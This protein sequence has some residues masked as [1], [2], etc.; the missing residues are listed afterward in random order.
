MT[1]SKY[2]TKVKVEIKTWA[3]E[4]TMVLKWILIR[5]SMGIY[6]YIINVV[7]KNVD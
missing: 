6:A 3:T 4:P 2:S 5:I 1:H 7:S